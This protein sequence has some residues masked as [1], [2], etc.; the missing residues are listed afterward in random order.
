MIMSI[1]VYF[2]SPRPSPKERG[3]LTHATLFRKGTG[4]NC[5]FNLLLHFDVIFLF[6]VIASEAKNRAT[7]CEHDW[8]LSIAEGEIHL[9]LSWTVVLSFEAPRLIEIC[10]TLVEMTLLRR[11]TPCND[12]DVLYFVV[13]SPS[14]G[15][16]G[17]AN[18][19]ETASEWGMPKSYVVSWIFWFTVC[20]PLDD[21]NVKICENATKSTLFSAGKPV[22]F[23]VKLLWDLLKSNILRAPAQV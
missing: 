3:L 9:F 18:K 7:K 21:A 15:G 12:D 20:K 4:R 23:F 19:K 6:F 14:L 16:V 11:C 5:L 2:A 22:K 8:T 17:E 1:F 13:Q 10:S